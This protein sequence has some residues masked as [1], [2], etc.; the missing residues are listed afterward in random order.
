VE[1]PV[2]TDA[3]LLYRNKY[4]DQSINLFPFI[5]DFNALTFEAGAKIYFYKCKDLSDG[6]L[7]Y[8]FLEDKAVVE[9]I[10]YKDVLKDNASIN[11]LMMDPD[12]RKVRKLDVV[13]EQF[14]DAR[15]TILP[16]VAQQQQFVLEDEEEE[17]F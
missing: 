5:I 9:N 6:S 2:A 10:L 14:Q 8:T 3:I 4:Q 16:A 1:V 7:N 11:Q 12:K 13:F 15:Q 17:E